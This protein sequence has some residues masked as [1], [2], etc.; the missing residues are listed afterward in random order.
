MENAG[1][2]LSTV[3]SFLAKN[4]RLDF[5]PQSIFLKKMSSFSSV[6]EDRLWCP[7]RVLNYYIKRTKE[8][9]QDQ[10]LF[11]THIAPFR[12]ASSSSIAR[13]LVEVIAFSP[14]S[15]AGPGTPLPRAHQVRSL[16]ASWALFNGVPIQD[17][18]QAA[19][20]RTPNTFISC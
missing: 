17:I 12:K 11:L 7:V 13:W 15:L 9:R 6:H 5:L 16:A 8:H 1:I 10:A 2:R 20:W 19:V 3:A 14:I 18:M 4:Q